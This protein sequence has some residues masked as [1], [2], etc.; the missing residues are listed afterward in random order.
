MRVHGRNI[1]QVNPLDTVEGKALVA[2][3]KREFPSTNGFCALGKDGSEALGREGVSPGS[4]IVVVS[5]S[6]SRRGERQSR[7]RR[8]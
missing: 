3:T 4:R 2:E 1:V 5:E 6:G 7:K 8:S